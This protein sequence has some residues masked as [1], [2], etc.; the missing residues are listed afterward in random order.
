MRSIV[1][2]CKISFGITLRETLGVLKANST[3]N[4]LSNSMYRAQ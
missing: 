3:T 2:V 4:L 1:A